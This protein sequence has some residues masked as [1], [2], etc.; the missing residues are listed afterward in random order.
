[1]S[2]SVFDY[3]SQIKGG[4]NFIM[5]S[6]VTLLCVSMCILYI[7]NRFKYEYLDLC[8]CV[9]LSPAM[10]VYIL[11]LNMNIYIDLCLC[12]SPSIISSLLENGE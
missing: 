12:L 4:W 11:Y 7:Y 3:K 10:F 9:C 6:V 5:G 2:K 8:L 1:M